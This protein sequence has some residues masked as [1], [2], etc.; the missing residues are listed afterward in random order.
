MV[1]PRPGKSQASSDQVPSPAGRN[2]TATAREVSGSSNDLPEVET[3]GCPAGRWTIPSAPIITPI[4][5]S[6]ANGVNSPRISA[7]P[8]QNSAIAAAASSESGTPASGPIQPKGSRILP[9]PCRMKAAPTTI[10]RNSSPSAPR[11]PMNLG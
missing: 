9:Q 3:N 5:P 6:A 7:A 4:S 2:V 10:R 8:P 11:P 1:R